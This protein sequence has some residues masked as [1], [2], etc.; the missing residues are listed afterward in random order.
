MLPSTLYIMSPIKVHSL[1]LGTKFEVAVSKG[2]R[3]D[4]FTRKATDGRTDGRTKD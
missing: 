4:T 3:G 2:L 1:K